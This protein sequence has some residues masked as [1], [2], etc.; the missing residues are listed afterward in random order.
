M[1][2]KIQT[3][4]NRLNKKVVEHDDESQMLL[5]FILYNMIQQYTIKIKEVY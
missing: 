1:I 2:Q 4:I 5:F 3:L